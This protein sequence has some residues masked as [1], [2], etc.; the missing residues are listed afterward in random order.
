MDR[1]KK[2]QKNLRNKAAEACR[3]ARRFKD[4]TALKN[5]YEGRYQAYKN[6]ARLLEI[7][8]DYDE[9]LQEIRGEL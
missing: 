4:I 9:R 6:S 7:A 5:Y 1:T 8:V 2:L 3:S